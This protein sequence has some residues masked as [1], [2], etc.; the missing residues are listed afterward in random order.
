MPPVSP[1]TSYANYVIYF[2]N[3]ADVEAA[4]AL[5]GGLQF[6]GCPVK[7]EIAFGV[8]IQATGGAIDPNKGI[9][10]LAPYGIPGHSPGYQILF[11]GPSGKY[12]TDNHDS[13]LVPGQPFD[14]VNG[15]SMLLVWSGNIV[16]MGN[17]ADGSV[18]RAGIPQIRWA[19]GFEC[20]DS[21]EGP[22]FNG[23]DVCRDA[24]R[25]LDG[26]GI[27]L[28]NVSN[29]FATKL[30]NRYQ[31]GL[32]TAESWERFYFRVRSVGNTPIDIW[33][34]NGS[35]SSQTGIRLYL[36][37][38]L[39]F[40][41]YNVSSGGVETLLDT[42]TV[43]T[44]TVGRWNKVDV[45]PQYNTA[46]MGGSGTFRMYFNQTL[47]FTASVAAASGGLGTN[48]SKHAGS[49]LGTEIAAAN[50]DWEIDL[51]DWTN[52]AIP[53]LDGEE[54]LSS[55][56]WLGGTH[57]KRQN[58][59]SAIMPAYSGVAEAFNR[60]N[61]PATAIAEVTSSTSS[62]LV[63]ALTDVTDVQVAVGIVLAN[64]SAIITKYGKRANGPGNGELGYSLAGAANV[65]TSISES[66]ANIYNDI[67]YIGPADVVL[68][69]SFVPMNILYRKAAD[70]NLAT[71]IALTLF[72]QQLGT[73]GIEDDETLVDQMPQTL[74]LHNAP[75][76]NLMYSYFGP[77]PDAPVRT[78][79]GTYVGNGTVTTVDVLLPA[80]MIYIR[81]VDS[82]QSPVMWFS[83][84]LGPHTLGTQAVI[85][86]HMVRAY[87]DDT[88]PDNQFCRIV[89]VGNSAVSNQNGL[90][91][92]VVVFCD[93]AMRFMLNSACQHDTSVAMANNALPDTTFTPEAMFG[94]VELT[95]ASNTVKM[96]LKG[97]GS[98]TDA[99]VGFNGVELSDY[100]TFD[101]GNLISRTDF[102]VIGSQLTMA[103]F[104]TDD[105]TGSGIV[106]V[107]LATYT[108]DGSATR[109]IGLSPT[110]GKFPVLAIVVP[111]NGVEAVF[112]DPSHTS[113]DSSRL[114]GTIVTN[115]IKGGAQDSITVDILVNAN[116]VTYDV[117]VLVGDTNSWS[118]GDYAIPPTLPPGDFYPPSDGTPFDGFSILPEG[119][120]VIN[121]QPAIGLLKNVSGIYTIVE[122]KRNDTLYD[123]QTGQ[124]SVDV[125]IPDPR[126]KLGYIGG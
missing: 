23:L 14:G 105:Q 118:N 89:I 56:D 99:S 115:G 77:T 25:T 123:R 97:P 20:S 88:D 106:R 116:G 119:G 101:I 112:R 76:N 41:I 78:F 55:M 83:T 46:A 47:I 43:P 108:G 1:F 54:S 122:G 36:N 69:D 10:G 104:R 94:C 27:A 67:A 18:S 98:A 52:K 117:F 42:S 32:T 113:N 60:M 39:S 28:R 61:S 125:A 91:Y 107:Q 2:S 12:L 124:E 71:V 58:V 72:L 75:Y 121:G 90:T 8:T 9:M 100:A 96:T 68:P 31:T 50:N 114:N 24:S 4:I 30:V 81:A 64:L 3:E 103:M 59:I 17:G 35:P 11:P 49:Q 92:E 95:S 37:D 19:T 120:L 13:V 79:A 85:P 93:P 29:T 48:N 63:D 57:I 34:S 102:H 16:R 65:F 62:A 109:V 38:D 26:C 44:V 40:S 66:T 110:A 111:H 82:A 21:A 22:S 73:W 7:A 86:D 15:P 80:H 33:R 53:E 51:D 74:M 126:W 87:W 84:S 6:L 5:A 70:T 45:I